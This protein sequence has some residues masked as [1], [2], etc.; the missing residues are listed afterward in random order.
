LFLLGGIVVVVAVVDVFV[1]HL[2]AVILLPQVWLNKIYS[3][4]FFLAPLPC[5]EPL[6]PPHLARSKQGHLV[7]SIS[8]PC[9]RPRCSTPVVVLTSLPPL[10][11]ASSSSSK[12]LMYSCL[13]LRP[14]CSTPLVV[15]TSSPPPVE[16]ISSSSKASMYSRLRLRSCCSTPMVVPTSSSSSSKASMYSHLRLCPRLEAVLCFTIDPHRSHNS[17]LVVVSKSSPPP[18]TRLGGPSSISDDGE[19]LSFGRPVRSSWPRRPSLIDTSRSLPSR[20][21]RLRR[22]G[23]PAGE[24]TVIEHIDVVVVLIGS[25]DLVIFLVFFEDFLVN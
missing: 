6:F 17:T 2:T 18:G 19:P 25:V 14:C 4:P 7:S 21:K 15:P 3:P 20:C 24:L 22:L 23:G 9:L 10:I 11:E 8:P 16:A 5:S 13:R 1:G 12:A